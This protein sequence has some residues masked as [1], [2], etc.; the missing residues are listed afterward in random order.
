MGTTAN[1]GMDG[2]DNWGRSSGISIMKGASVRLV[3]PEG[4]EGHWGG[5]WMV[6]RGLAYL[7]AV[8]ASTALLGL[9]IHWL[10]FMGRYGWLLANGM[11]S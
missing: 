1:L 9:M 6:G 8:V 7:A 4:Q 11:V 3:A 5:L 10:V 2:V